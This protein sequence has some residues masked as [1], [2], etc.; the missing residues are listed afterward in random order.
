MRTKNWPEDWQIRLIQLL[1]VPGLVLS[2]YLLLYHNGNLVEVCSASGWDDCGKV[3]GPDAPYSSIGPIPVALIGLIGYVTLFLVTWLKDWIPLV[4]DY[5][6]ELMIGLTGVA[7]L[8]SVGLTV[9][10]L[11]VIHAICRFC[12]VSAV[13]VIIMFVLSL[14][15]LRTLG[16]PRE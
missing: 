9:L 2:F 6:P 12:I 13:I 16:E 8:F 4:D 5:L 1:A 3:S 7:L 11:F 15:Y 10:E 14:S